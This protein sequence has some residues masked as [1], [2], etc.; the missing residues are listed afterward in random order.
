MSESKKDEKPEAPMK[1]TPTG[2]SI[3]ITPQG[4]LD[5]LKKA[6]V[7]YRGTLADHQALQAS[8][9]IVTSIV[10]SWVKEKEAQTPSGPATIKKPNR[11][12][13]R[14]VQKANKKAAAKKQASRRATKKASSSKTSNGAAART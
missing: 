6:A 5:Y 7:D 1:G 3:N 11:K 13:R 8:H 14:A 4:A 10:Q 9:A 2:R 12:I